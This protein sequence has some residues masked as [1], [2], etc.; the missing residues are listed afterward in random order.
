[1]IRGLYNPCCFNQRFL[2]YTQ[3]QN[4]NCFG[5]DRVCFISKF[6]SI[7]KLCLLIFETS[8]NNLV[9]LG[10][11]LVKNLPAILQLQR[12]QFNSWVGK[13]CWRNDRLLNSLFLGSLEAQLVKNLLAMRET[14]VWSMGWEDP[15]EEGKATHSSILAGRTPWTL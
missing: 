5:W 12:H 13:I 3:A 9:S 1:M 8:W 15:L 10:A 11:Q 2:H 4:L 14:W 6:Q 7:K